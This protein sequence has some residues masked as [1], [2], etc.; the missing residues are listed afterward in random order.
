MR[1][2]PFGPLLVGDRP[3]WLAHAQHDEEESVACA[4]HRGR[5]QARSVAACRAPRLKLFRFA[6][7][8]VSQIYERSP[9]F[10]VFRVSTLGF[11]TVSNKKK[12]ILVSTP[13]FRSLG[14]HSLAVCTRGEKDVA[15]I[16]AL[17]RALVIYWC[18]GTGSKPAW[19]QPD[20][21]IIATLET[22]SDWNA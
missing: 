1:G 4:P 7:L 6:I 11:C 10:S 20:Q 17:S 18:R 3:G 14:S 15:K 21:H 2:N 9:W 8:L 5:A 12:H 13:Q 19:I 22:D 16:F